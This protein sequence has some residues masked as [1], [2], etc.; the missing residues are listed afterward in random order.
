MDPPLDRERH[1]RYLLRCLRTLLPH[2]YTSNDS[3][4]MTLGG[5]TVAA[6]DLL[7]S[8]SADAPKPVLTSHDRRLFRD[9]VLACQH[10]AGG[11]A[12]SPTH[13]LPRHQ[14][15]G[16]DFETQQAT[17]G[18][19]GTANIAATYF[20][21]QLLALLAA[22]DTAESAFSGIDRIATL[23]WLR[24]LQRDDGSFGEVVV[25]IP[26]HARKKKWTIS[27]GRDMRYCYIAAAIRW[28][29]RGDVCEGQTTWVEDINVDALAGYIKNAQTYDGGFSESSTHESHGT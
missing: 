5:F 3:I 13:A 16:Y 19:P 4:R 21:L 12:G 6:I 1:L 11:F 7:T 20:A 17:T 8:S 23:N 25:Q 27:G 18:A 10:P 22:E 15:D 29:L 24:R 2:Q 9:W 26:D 28:V 14:Y